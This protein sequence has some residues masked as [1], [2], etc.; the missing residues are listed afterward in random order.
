[1]VVWSEAR[2]EVKFTT[3]HGALYYYEPH[4]VW[5]VG[6]GPSLRGFDFSKLT[7]EIIAVNKA[8][9]EPT[10]NWTIGLSMDYGF[11]KRY[12]E[13]LEAEN[14]GF[15]R[16]HVGFRDEKVPPHGPTEVFWARKLDVPNPHLEPYW[17]LDSRG[18]G[19]GGNSGFAALNY[20]DICCMDPIG[21]LGFDM[22]GDGQGNQAWWHDGYE[23]KQREAVYDRMLEAFRTAAPKIR[24]R[25]EV[26]GPSRLDCFPKRPLP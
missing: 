4:P 21:L 15:H 5:I 7:G 11:W 26:Y 19:M 3:T 20:A 24:S 10:L 1:M 6:G 14:R 17:G 25:V 18:I 9:L 2:V 12:G 22:Q 13:Q 16:V 8:M 23:E